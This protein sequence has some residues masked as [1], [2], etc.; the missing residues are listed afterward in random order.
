MGKGSKPQADDRDS[1]AVIEIDAGRVFLNA[2]HASAMQN[3][4]RCFANA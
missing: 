1:G 4:E 2:F 3:E